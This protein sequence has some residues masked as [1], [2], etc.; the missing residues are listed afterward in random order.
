MMGMKLSSAHSRLHME[1]CWQ[2]QCSLNLTKYKPCNQT[3]RNHRTYHKTSKKR[4]RQ[5]SLNAGVQ[6]RKHGFKCRVIKKVW[7]SNWGLKQ[8]NKTLW[9]HD[10]TKKS[11]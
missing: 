5:P 2:M 9:H 1:I 11:Q 7:K 6:L 8:Q 4:T 10:G 3:C